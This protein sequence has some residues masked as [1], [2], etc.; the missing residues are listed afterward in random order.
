MKLVQ[1][2]VLLSLAFFV[3]N[4]D[5]ETDPTTV[6]KFIPKVN[7]SAV[8]TTTALNPE[9][10]QSD[11]KWTASIS[12]NPTSDYNTADAINV[13]TKIGLSYKVIDKYKISLAHGFESVPLLL[14]KDDLLE[15]AKTNNFR[16]MYT[17]IGVSNTISGIL[18]SDDISLGLLARILSHDS[19]YNKTLDAGI[20]SKYDIY[21]SVPYTIN[22]KTS[23]SLFTQLRH[24]QKVAVERANDH[25]ANRL[26]FGPSISY[27]FNDQ[28]SVYQILS[29]MTSFID[30]ID[31]RR[32]RERAYL[33]TG[34]KITPPIKGL[35]ISLNINQE[36]EISAKRGYTVTPFTLYRPNDG[37]LNSNGD[38]IAANGEKILDYVSYAALISYSF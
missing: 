10:I 19:I 8:N 6:S 27:A 5:A 37:V 34:L 7:Q 22:P 18:K 11:K 25:M 2:L 26:I 29:S 28:I 3:Q 15:D 17:D 13:I 21:V 14:Q 23:L 12:L 4:G 1:L 31:F 38:N 16:S 33:E 35:S 36:K 30:G 9:V 20:R 32:S 24:Y